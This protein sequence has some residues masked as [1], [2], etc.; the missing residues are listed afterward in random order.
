MCSYHWTKQKRW[1]ENKVSDPTNK[2]KEK[3]ERKKTQHQNSVVEF[4][5]TRDPGLSGD[6]PV[7]P[8]SKYNR[9]SS[10]FFLHLIIHCDWC[11]S[12]LGHISPC[13][14]WFEKSASWDVA[15]WAVHFL[16]F[17]CNCFCLSFVL[18]FF[19]FFVLAPLC[20][21]TVWPCRREGPGWCLFWKA[22]HWDKYFRVSINMLAAMQGAQESGARKSGLSWN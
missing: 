2:T 16:K 12:S 7:G 22:V 14:F 9:V 4:T 11:H 21:R 5:V 6:S 13:L 15:R 19:F 20:P 8:I 3:H 10:V 18:F 17:L 1:H